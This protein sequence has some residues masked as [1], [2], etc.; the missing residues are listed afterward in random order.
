MSEQKPAS[1]QK[2]MSIQVIENPERGLY[3]EHSR[4]AKL[5]KLIGQP[6]ADMIIHHALETLKSSSLIMTIGYEEAGVAVTFKVKELP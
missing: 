5:Q 3:V 1:V 4:K 6:F 2:T